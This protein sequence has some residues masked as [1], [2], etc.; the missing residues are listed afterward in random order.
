MFHLFSALNLDALL[1][2][3]IEYIVVSLR[4]L[5]CYQMHRNDFNECIENEII[6]KISSLECFVVISSQ[7]VSLFF[8]FW[9][10]FNNILCQF[11]IQIINSD[12]TLNIYNKYAIYEQ[13]TINT[14]NICNEAIKI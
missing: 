2:W 4:E 12:D 14:N 1:I 5:Q 3:K 11:I 6:F 7:L 13:Y 8:F 10:K 9:S